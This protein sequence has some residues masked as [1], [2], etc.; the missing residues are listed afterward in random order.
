M[1]VI[2]GGECGGEGAC[3]DGGVRNEM[4]DWV[5]GNIIIIRVRGSSEHC[6]FVGVVGASQPPV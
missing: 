5:R 4:G 1:F 3:V 6:A 2:G